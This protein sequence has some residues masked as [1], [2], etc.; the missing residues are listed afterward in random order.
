MESSY[1]IWHLG[2]HKKHGK[3]KF[4]HKPPLLKPP[5]SYEDAW[6]LSQTLS[7]NILPKTHRDHNWHTHVS[8]N[9]K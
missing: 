3:I 6:L 9:C 8:L 1:V 7:Q 2:N 5:T 4:Y